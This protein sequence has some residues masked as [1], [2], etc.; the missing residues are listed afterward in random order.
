MSLSR[1]M[2]ADRIPL[3]FCPRSSPTMAADFGRIDPYRLLIGNEAGD[4]V[5]VEP[6]TKDHYGDIPMVTRGLHS[7]PDAIFDAIWRGDDHRYAL[8]VADNHVYVHDSSSGA[9]VQCLGHH[10]SSI[11]TVRYRP[12]NPHIITTAGRDGCIAIWDLRNSDTNSS[13]NRPISVIQ[14]AHTIRSPNQSGMAAETNSSVTAFD[15][16]PLEDH[17]IASIGQPDYDIRFWDLRYTWRRGMPATFCGK[18]SAPKGGRRQRA[19]VSICVDSGGSFVYAVSSDNHIYKYLTSNFCGDPVDIYSG[20]GFRTSGSFY[21]RSS[22]SPDDDF[23][24]CG[25]TEGH[26]YIW[27]TSRRRSNYFRLYEHRYEVSC[28][29]W[30]QSNHIFIGGEDY[31]SRL[32]HSTSASNSSGESINKVDPVRHVTMEGIPIENPINKKSMQKLNLPSWKQGLILNPP[33]NPSTLSSLTSWPRRKTLSLINDNDLIMRTPLLNL[34]NSGTPIKKRQT[35]IDSFLTPPSPFKKRH[36]I[37][38]SLT[39][40]ERIA[41]ENMNPTDKS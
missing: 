16:M 5:L 20:K 21:I 29:A 25:S 7:Y 10:N 1:Q 30:S 31:V 11:R 26:A 18:I 32:W 40:P 23:L 37:A 33:I 2:Y 19:F 17:L 34:K 22:L 28:V 13:R 6:T 14:D 8:A 15:F 12:N 41:I 35:I 38:S 39:L 4:V 27:P 9:V 36:Q 24:L 3:S